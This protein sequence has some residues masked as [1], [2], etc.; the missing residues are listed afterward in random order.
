MHIVVF[1]PSIFTCEHFFWVFISFCGF[2]LSEILPSLHI[3]L[4][5][6]FLIKLK[7]KSSKKDRKLSWEVIL[8]DL[9]Q[10]ILDFNF[11]EFLVEFVA[12]KFAEIIFTDANLFALWNLPVVLPL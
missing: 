6:K 3:Y 4:I 12:E 9:K 7:E 11:S 8:F 5:A 1:P 10:V 2:V